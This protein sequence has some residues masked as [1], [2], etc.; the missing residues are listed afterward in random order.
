MDEVDEKIGGDGNSNDTVKLSYGFNDAGEA[1]AVLGVGD[2]NLR[3]IQE[4]TRAKLVARGNKVLL[5]GSP[6]EVALLQ[7]V[8][9]NLRKIVDEGRDVGPEDVRLL[10]REGPQGGVVRKQQPEEL[11]IDAYQIRIRPR[12]RGQDGYMRSILENPMTF[13][14][15]PAGSGKTYIAVAMAVNFLRTKRAQRIILTRPAVEAGESLGFL[16]GDLYEKVAPYF[17]PLYDA[18]FEMLGVERTR[19]M[20]DDGT[21]EIAPLAYMRGRTLNKSFIIL[22]EGQNTTLNQ[23]KMFLTRM[24]PESRAVI[25]G[26]VTQIDLPRD[27][28]SG[29]NQAWRLL[30]GIPGIGFAELT[31][32]DIVRH[33]LVQKIV[34]AYEREEKRLRARENADNDFDNQ[35]REDKRSR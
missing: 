17:R 2:R 21:I 22:D 29:L 30:R 15:G 5:S 12:T 13:C 1:M 9:D 19:K 18:L 7:F 27:T 23:M 6:D 32:K 26:D 34:L 33:H 20:I 25:T 16:P 8:F 4:N 11:V 10:M 35:G 3:I 24:G 28:P 14:I 31:E